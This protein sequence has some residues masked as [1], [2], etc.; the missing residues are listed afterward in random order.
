[1]SLK[2]VLRAAESLSARGRV[3]QAGVTPRKLHAES[4]RAGAAPWTRA[5]FVLPSPL[6]LVALSISPRSRSR[7]LE[8]KAY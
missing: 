4:G 6:L 1:M 8:S 5:P 3:T 7:L 2:V